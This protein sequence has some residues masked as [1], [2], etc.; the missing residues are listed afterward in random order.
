MSRPRPSRHT[1]TQ[2]RRPRD[3]V[4][5]RKLPAELYYLTAMSRAAVVIRV[6]ASLAYLG[7]L[8]AVV[9]RRGTVPMS[10]TV[11]GAIG[12]LVALV[13]LWRRR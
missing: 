4:E 1:R 3:L 12:T 13:A 2:S 8:I 7:L 9:V 10:A 11:I 6:V 5:P